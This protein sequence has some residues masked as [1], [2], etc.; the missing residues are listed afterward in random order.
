MERIDRLFKLLDD[1]SLDAIFVLKPLNIFYFTGAYVNGLLYIGGEKPILFVRRP[2]E[3]PLNSKA[4][5]VYINSFKD[6]KPFISL[7]L[8]NVG[9]ELDSIPYN[10]VLKIVSTF[11]IREVFDISNEIRLIRMKKDEVEIE[12]I[13]RAGEIVGGVFERVREVFTPG[14]TEFDLL[15]ELEYFSKKLG[16]LGV[17]RMHSF[18]NEASFSH[19]IQGD[20]AFFPSYLDAPTGGRGISEAF[21]QGASL[22]KIES[23][24][25]FTVD[26]MINYDGYIA[27]ATRTFIY[28]EVS[29]EIKDY[30]GKLISIFRFVRDLL[31]PGNICED[32]YSKTLAYVDS[33]GMGNLFM[34][35][36][37]D[38]VKFIGHGVGLEVDEFPFI[39]KGF[40][41][42]LE[43]SMVVAV[44]PKIFDRSFGIM[45][46]EDTFLIE[47]EGAKTL[48]P[49]PQ[50]LT[51]L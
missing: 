24:K 27:D 10:T 44:E 32:I 22:R 9:L 35:T 21:P 4:E 47:K 25:P 49:F 36:G 13:K 29:N 23:G 51:V 18:G 30:W 15:L 17:Y 5:V 2:K 8:N 50:E 39:A 41:L 12:K 48:I 42:Q 28:G 34:G 33:L 16:N 46:I 45:G 11:G 7:S 38:R 31:V 40:S 1:K 37:Q 14:M 6:I 26:V 3:R 19:I 20:D 43:Q